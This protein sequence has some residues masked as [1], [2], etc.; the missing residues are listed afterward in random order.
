ME[1]LPISRSGTRF[2][3]QAMLAS[4]WTSLP[5]A[6]PHSGISFRACR[7]PLVQSVER[8]RKKIDPEKSAISRSVVFKLLGTGSVVEEVRLCD[9]TRSPEGEPDSQA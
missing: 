4:S 7:R 1:S 2:W 3:R 5:E 6:G 8:R 9:E